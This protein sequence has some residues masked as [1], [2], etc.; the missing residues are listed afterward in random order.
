MGSV[1]FTA[2]LHLGHGN[3]IRYCLR[4]FLS[5]AERE[6]ARRDPR[7][8]WRVS[9]ETLQRHDDALLDAINTSVQTRDTL[10]ILGDFCW[11]GIERAPHREGSSRL[12]IQPQSLRNSN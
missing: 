11:G 1:W 9:E 12:A 3:I 6:R 4:P 10:W 8:K 2:D 5:S 7:A